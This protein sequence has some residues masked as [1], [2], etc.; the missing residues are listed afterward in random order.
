[1][2][3]LLALLLVLGGMVSGLRSADEDN[4]PA[5]PEK[6]K[7][8]TFFIVEVNRQVIATPK[9]DDNIPKGCVAQIEARSSEEA[10]EE[11]NRFYGN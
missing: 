2:K 3:K 1:M 5:Q 11:Y 10:L 6:N 4:P 8:A 7:V 9:E